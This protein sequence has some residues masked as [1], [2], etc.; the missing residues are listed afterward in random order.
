MHRFGVVNA[1]GKGAML[2]TLISLAAHFSY[3]VSRFFHVCYDCLLF[4][5]PVYKTR[6]FSAIL[7]MLKWFAGHQIRNVAVSWPYIKW[8]RSLSNN[9]NN[10]NY[11]RS[12][13]YLRR[14]LMGKLDKIYYG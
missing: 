9:D 6:W 11:F 14:M 4:N 1:E 3:A 13:E 8:R 2:L 12:S 10:D 5:F 7:H